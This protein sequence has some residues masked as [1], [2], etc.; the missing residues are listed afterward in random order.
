MTAADRPAIRGPE[1]PGL[2]PQRSA[3]AWSRTSLAVLANAVLILQ[4]DFHDVAVLVPGLL[5]LA[6]AVA[7]AGIGWQRRAVLR[8]RPLPARLAASRQ[9][10]A[11]GWSVVA[12][13]AVTMGLLIR[14]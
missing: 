5:A 12:L 8:R 7:T 6:I 1:D 14:S 4:R 10:H 9:V 13:S 11:L 3:L 2:Q